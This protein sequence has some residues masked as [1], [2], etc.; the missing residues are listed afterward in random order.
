MEIEFD[1]DIS[2]NQDKRLDQNFNYLIRNMEKLGE[3]SKSLKI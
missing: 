1:F 2:L 3:F